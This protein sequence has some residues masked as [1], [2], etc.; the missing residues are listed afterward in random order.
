MKRRV[1]AGSV[2]A[3]ILVGISLLFVTV[4]AWADCTTGWMAPT[5]DDAHEGLSWTNGAGGR[6]AYDESR[7]STNEN[8]D[9]HEYDNYPFVLGV[10]IPVG[11]VITGFEVRI[12]GYDGNV[13]VYLSHDGGATLDDPAP[14]AGRLII[15]WAG[16]GNEGW[17]SISIPNPPFI[18]TFTAA[19]VCGGNDAF[20]VVCKANVGAGETLYV[21]AVEV[22]VTYY[23][24]TTPPF[25]PNNPSASSSSHST[26][27]WYN[28]ETIGSTTVDMSW[29]S[30][31]DRPACGSGIKGYRA[32]WDTSGATVLGAGDGYFFDEAGSHAYDLLEIGDGEHWFHIRSVD[33]AENLADATLHVGPFRYDSAWP[34]NP[35]VSSTT[36]TGWS[37]SASIPVSVSGASDATSGVD[38]FA[39][40][41]THS[42]TW[43]V[44]EVKDREEGW[45]GET[46]TL[47]ADG[48]WYF[49]VGTVDNAGN[50]VPSVLYETLGW[51]GVDTHAPTDPG[52][53]SPT[54][55]EGGH[56]N[57]P[58]VQIAASGASDPDY[59]EPG[60]E[61]SSGVDGFSGLWDHS[62]T[63]TPDAV[64]DYEQGWTGTTYTLADGTWYFHLRTAD[65]AGNWTSTEDYGPITIDT[66]APTVM[67][68]ANDVLITDSDA[69]LD[70]FLVAATY[71]EEMNPA[72]T[73]TLTFAP[74]VSTTFTNPSGAWSSG[75]TVYTWA[76][77]VADRG[78]TAADVD[79]TVSGAQD[80]AG[81]VQVSKTD[82]DYVD[83]DTQ[84]PTVTSVTASDALL[85]DGDTP[86]SA[87]FSLTV[88][89]SEAMDT[90]VAPILTL[91][92]AVGTTLALDASSGWADSDTY[93]ARYD[94]VDANVDVESVTVDV[95]GAR[96]EVGNAQ[97]DYTPQA[98][99]SIDTQNPTVS[100]AAND[101][102]IYDGDVG[103]DRFAVTA[104]YSEAMDPG[105]APAMIFIPGMGTTFTNPSGA[106]GSGN[107]VYTWTYDV[108]DDGATV[109][110]VDLFVSGGAD[111]SGNTQ[112]SAARADYIDVDL[113]NP[114][115][116]ISANDLA[117]Y[118]GDVG[119]DRFIVTATF[120]EAMNPS[121]APTLTFAPAAGTTFRTPTMAWSA[122]NTVYTWTYDVADAGVNAQDV[123]L[124]VSGGRDVAGNAQVANTNADYVDID[125]QNPWVTSAAA[126]DLLISDAD[127]GG[128]LLVT[129][130]FSESMRPTDVPTLVFGPD[131]GTT[132]AYASGTWVDA[133]TYQ[134]SY[135]ISDA[136]VDVNSVTVDV[137]NARDSSGNAQTN[138]AP[139]QEFEIDTR[140]PRS[141]VT[142]DRT[143]VADGLPVYEGALVL[144]VTVTYD[145]PMNTLTAPTVSLEEGGTHWG[146]QTSLGWTGNTVYRATFTHDG[147]QEP[148][149][150]ETAIA[151]YTRVLSGSGATDVAGNADVGDDSPAFEID[152]R[153]PRATVVVDHTTIADG[154]PIYEGDLTVLVTVT[155]DEPMDTSTQPAIALPGGGTHWGPQAP[156]GW[157]GDTVYRAMFTHD[158][159]EEPTPPDAPPLAVARVAD[160]SG[161]RDLAGNA[162]VGADSSAFE[163]DTRRPE[164]APTVASVI[165]DTDPVYEGDLVQTV[166]VTFDEAMR[167]DGS[168]EPAITFGGGSWIAGTPGIWSDG[169]TVWTR[170]YTLIDRDEEIHDVTI[171]VSGTRD[172]AG[173]RQEDYVASPEFTIDT[174]QPRIVEIDARGP[175]SCGGLTCSGAGGTVVVSVIFSEDVVLSAG[176][177]NVVLDVVPGGY[178]VVYAP[179]EF[180][181][182]EDFPDCWSD[183]TIEQDYV[184]AAGHNSCDLES[185]AV[186]WSVGTLTDAAG[187]L[188]IEAMPPVGSRIAAL[189]DIVVD[190][191]PPVAVDD[192]GSG[193]DYVY[194]QPSY[195]S[196]HEWIEDRERIVVREGT[197]IYIDVLSNDVDNCTAALSVIDANVPA[198]SYGATSLFTGGGD[199]EYPL[200]GGLCDARVVRYAPSSDYTGPD[201]F[202]YTARDCSGNT[203][204]AMVYLY[205][206]A[207][208]VLGS[209]VPN[210]F[211]GIPQ[212]FELETRDDLL[213]RIAGSERF[214][215]RFDVPAATEHGVLAW[216]DEDAVYDVGLGIVGLGVTYT[217]A[218]GYEGVDRFSWSVTDPFGQ[219]LERNEAFLVVQPD[220]DLAALAPALT[221]PPAG[222]GFLVVPTRSA[223]VVDIRIEV[224][225]ALG[226]V[227]SS[228]EPDAVGEAVTIDPGRGVGVLAVH[229]AKLPQ[230]LVRLWIPI[231]DGTTCSLVIRIGAGGEL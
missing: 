24:E 37:N 98:E 118:D 18:H 208:N 213:L 189:R 108:V 225:G 123:D 47:P 16:A 216:T 64:K 192:P 172:I 34:S 101:T 223:G 181:A 179:S 148:L 215:Y 23:E 51:F 85:S 31:T 90:G 174:L 50:W 99:F 134:T 144:T 116:V 82:A 67:I 77:D 2:C 146:G 103:V 5:D 190:T 44:D 20:T 8:G 138:Y 126:S 69:G 46:F 52:V 164:I 30:A 220:A 100:I 10:D 45:G 219:T 43:S 142:V 107:T 119:A 49:H 209:A 186:D 143:P 26:G 178:D 201:E 218:E 157:T 109:L 162:D 72:V 194:V 93:V 33:N 128:T 175:T 204:S 79:V 59:G 207:K 139:V 97:Q 111:V 56:S 60:Y 217:S 229:A 9:M 120:S 14:G 29:T 74:E 160:S 48:V 150:P 112:V 205:V 12:R 81:N 211:S 28:P 115:V 125:T 63:G 149:L 214:A 195:L 167:A 3:A 198:P 66:Q 177:M 35:D 212:S 55:A 184:V 156:L 136:G 19:E 170:T 57:N 87:T 224:L 71:S 106:W 4:T 124:T 180:D 153:K 152:T 161:A 117:I 145:E 41:W 86:G 171:D 53:S 25:T 185:T 230:G 158:G 176:T 68:E 83:V 166:T 39:I 132:L 6:T 21:D 147:T 127:A 7:A 169:D 40:A 17:H 183:Y 27:V 206:F 182:P 196:W 227:L 102:A 80:L 121:Y 231:G 91:A 193:V 200:L 84:N 1:A 122:G 173:N 188:A 191:T 70:R 54:H 141:A 15:L 151:A 163:I 133:N 96:D 13:Q 104:T 89:F 110:D 165:A 11:A 203:S 75:N 222:T 88:D 114:T 154:S 226:E 137:I 155:Y 94:T 113:Q 129:V 221:L 159:A 130:D 58:D 32:V 228:L 199:D 210:A 95:G 140:N 197:P 62:A 131:V 187:N 73:P 36:P 78:V 168:A 22:R 61:T 105:V 65:N 38:G 76:Y 42:G 135:T 202:G 92:P